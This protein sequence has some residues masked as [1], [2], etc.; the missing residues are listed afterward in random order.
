MAD[1]G[2]RTQPEDGEGQHGPGAGAGASD[3]DG[4]KRDGKS[5]A[6][7]KVGL[8]FA[9]RMRAYLLTGV[10]VT[11]PISIT[12]Y[13]AWLFIDLVDRTVTPLIPAKYHPETYLP[14]SI[15]GLGLLIVLVSLTLIGALT[16]GFMGKLWLRMQETVLARVPVIRSVYGATK[17][18]LETVLAQQSQAFRQAVL[19]EYPRRGMWAI[20]FITGR[21]EGEVQNLTE[22]ETVNVFL[23]TTP[24]PTS[25]FLLF[26]P[27]KDLVILNMTVE[28]A[29]KM[30]ISGGIV[31]PPDRRTPEKRSAPQVTAA[32]YEDVDILRERDRTPVL[33]SRAPVPGGDDSSG[34]E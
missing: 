18:I 14:F 31:T 29:I 4:L 15:P 6:S 26:V 32:T 17:Q 22:E 28:E 21:T 7:V 24:N 23:P 11:A 20:A 30:V 1:K 5:E 10:L 33:V 9:A 25:G 3:K 12:I 13:L 16:A 2:R 34:V 8:G 27:R 19:V